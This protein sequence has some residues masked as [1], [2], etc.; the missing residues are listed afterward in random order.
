[1]RQFIADFHIHSRFSRATSKNLTLEELDRVAAQKGIQVLGTGDFVHPRWLAE[2]KA[3][4]KEEEQGLYKL[5]KSKTDVRFIL[6]VEISSIYSKNGRVYR[7]HTL[8]FAPSLKVAEKISKKLDKVGNIHSDGRPIFGLDVRDLAE[9][10]FEIDEKAMIIPAHI[11]TPWFSILGS[12]SGFD[13]IED[14]Y[15]DMSKYIFALETGLSSDPLMNWRC[16]IL[17]NY[18]LIS[19]SDSHSSAK[20]G[21]EANILSCD[22]SYNGIYDALRKKKGKIVKTIEYFPEEGRYFYDGHRNCSVSRKPGKSDK[23]PACKKQMTIGV[24]NRVL[25]L[26]DRKEGYV[27]ARAPEFIKLIPLK[28]IIASIYGFGVGTKK[29]QGVYDF[30]LHRF[31]T[32]FNILLNVEIEE[33][34]QTGLTNIAT[35]IENVRKGNVSITPG[36]DGEYGVIKAIK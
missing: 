31:D 1:M 2:L 9:L 28:E 34:A 13:S 33:I 25:K 14:A 10:V 19:N 16:S 26:A 12:K 32:E 8:I 35:G 6:T 17:D 23:C 15:E 22:M 5:K 27:L 18:T 24:L 36:Y 11:W 7:I 30:L 3:Y 20:I 21:R 4:L 29:V